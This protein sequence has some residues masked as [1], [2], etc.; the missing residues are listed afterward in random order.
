MK[1][2]NISVISKKLHEIEEI[3]SLVNISS[4]SEVVYKYVFGVTDFEKIDLYIKVFTNENYIVISKLNNY[5]VNE[6]EVISY[7]FINNTKNIIELTFVNNNNIFEYLSGNEKNMIVF[8]K[9]RVF[10]DLSEQKSNSNWIMPKEDE[11]I[12][13]IIQFLFN[14]SEI[15]LCYKK[16]NYIKVSLLKNDLLDN[17][18]YMLNCYISLKY[19]NHVIVNQYGNGLR[20]YLEEQKFNEFEYIVLE[21]S[22]DDIWTIIFKSAQLYRTIGLYISEKL[23]YTYPKREDVKIMNILREIYKEEQWK[24]G[25]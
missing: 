3:R 11:F 19:N 24:K 1:E 22:R 25:F 6:Y 10:K 14:L 16:K 13:E 12:E 8:D 5:F 15:A 2:N 18:I 23:K 17:L 20:D 4:K 21:S 7:K 9:D